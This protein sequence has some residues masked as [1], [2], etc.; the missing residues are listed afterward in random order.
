MK[1][2]MEHGSCTENV[3]ERLI[4]A[5][6][7]KLR[8]E[9]YKLR[10]IQQQR[11]STRVRRQLV[12]NRCGRWRPL[13]ADPANHNK[14]LTMCDPTVILICALQMCG[15]SGCSSR[16]S[17][18][19]HRN[20]VTNNHL[21]NTRRA[22]LGSFSAVWDRIDLVLH[23]RQFFLQKPSIIR[24]RNIKSKINIKLCISY[25][26]KLERVHHKHG[27]LLFWWQHGI[28]HGY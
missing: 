17:R 13:F 7:I 18:T 26:A 4:I 24:A 2:K 22:Y 11:V 25:L 6:S 27:K 15:S 12:F 5:A 9:K 8:G 28:V 23:F 19:D 21:R 3:F 1:R 20:T 10:Y 14:C 16:W